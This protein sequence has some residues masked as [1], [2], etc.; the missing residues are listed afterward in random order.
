MKSRPIRAV[1]P[2][3]PTL[4]SILPLGTVP[5]R[6]RASVSS[7][8]REW[9]YSWSDVTFAGTAQLPSGLRWQSAGAETWVIAITTGP[10]DVGDEIDSAHGR[11]AGVHASSSAG[12]LM[13]AIFYQAQVFEVL[14]RRDGGRPPEPTIPPDGSGLTVTPE[15]AAA[16]PDPPR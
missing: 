9:G 7:V 14:G 11:I 5:V 3:H 6:L 16:A 4:K 2:F 12:A 1:D 13:P 10:I 15:T 8:L